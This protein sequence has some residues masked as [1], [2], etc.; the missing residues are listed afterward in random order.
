MQK[1]RTSKSVEETKLTTEDAYYE[2]NEAKMHD[3]LT[4][5]GISSSMVDSGSVDHM[6]IDSD[7]QEQY[8]MLRNLLIFH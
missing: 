3:S 4:E 5:S 8:K 6:D 2:E 1:N 7:N